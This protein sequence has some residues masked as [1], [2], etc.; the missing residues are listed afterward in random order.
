MHLF[1]INGLMQ[2]AKG[3]E[4]MNMNLEILLIKS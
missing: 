3:R 2:L 1:G 4:C